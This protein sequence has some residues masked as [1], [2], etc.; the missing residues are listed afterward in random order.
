MLKFTDFI[1]DT[2][3][4]GDIFLIFQ[5]AYL[6]SILYLAAA[7]K[8]FCISHRKT[9]FATV[10]VNTCKVN[11]AI[12]SEDF[13]LGSPRNTSIE[14]FRAIGYIQIK[15]EPRSIGEKFPNL[16]EFSVQKCG[17]TIVRDF[18][19]KHMQ[20]LE[21]LDLQFNQ[22]KTI[23]AKAFDDLAS[24]RLL[25]LA[26]NK[27]ETLDEKLFVKLVNLQDIWLQG[28]KIKFLSPTTFKV[29]G[30]V[31][32]SLVWLQTNDCID[33]AY[34]KYLDELEPD[35]RANCTQ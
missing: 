12:D 7:K 29:P 30:N 19:F 26:N 3:V 8:V 23:E 35:L 32:L 25:V 11:Q 21:K 6:I 15:F 16:K 34:Y 17:L 2:T 20:R 5:Y 18:N 27:I 28:N 4:S 9:I 33:K 24:L 13:F 10:G 22:I 1:V 31:N 14:I